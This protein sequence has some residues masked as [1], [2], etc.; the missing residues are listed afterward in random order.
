VQGTILPGVTRRSVIELARSRGYTVEEVPVTVEEAMQ[1]DE[2]GGGEVVPT[3]W[4]AGWLVGW[5][6][7]LLCLMGLRG[8]SNDCTSTPDLGGTW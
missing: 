3:T 5:L 8:M 6:V 2:V 4:L 1:S 7:A